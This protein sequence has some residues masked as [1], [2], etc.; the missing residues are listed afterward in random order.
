MDGV[1]PGH[2]F[3]TNKKD[4][5][6]R[7]QPSRSVRMVNCHILSP[8]V[9]RSEPIDPRDRFDSYNISF[10]Y[11]PKSQR[12]LAHHQSVSLSQLA[13]GNRNI[14]GWTSPAPDNVTAWIASASIRR[15]Q[16]GRTFRPTSTSTTSSRIRR[17]TQ[18]SF[19]SRLSQQLFRLLFGPW[20]DFYPINLYA[21]TYGTVPCSLFW[22]HD[23]GPDLSCTPSNLTRQKGMYVQ[24]LHD[25][26]SIVFNSCSAP[27]TTSRSF[28]RASLRQRYGGACRCKGGADQES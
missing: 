8:T 9:F 4:A 7:R 5:K 25:L 21:P 10:R 16:T 17:Q 6:R 11:R 13:L 28:V 3:F 14:T 12:G 15:G 26:F 2:A 22:S 23:G 27:A 20:R 1:H 19:R 24:E 18:R